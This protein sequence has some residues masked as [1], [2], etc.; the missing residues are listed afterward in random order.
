MATEIKLPNLSNSL[1][2]VLHSDFYKLILE[3]KFMLVKCRC[4]VV[5]EGDL[6]IKEGK[7]LNYEN[8]H[9]KNCIAGLDCYFGSKDS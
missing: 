5:Q 4:E 2:E 3:D 6:E 1:C 7:T 9:F 8:I